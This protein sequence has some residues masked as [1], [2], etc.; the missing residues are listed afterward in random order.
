VGEGQEA[1]L[2]EVFEGRP[3]KVSG[4]SLQD[5]RQTVIR[6]MGQLWI[7]FAKPHRP[8]YR[9]ALPS[10]ERASPEEKSAY[11]TFKYDIS[12]SNYSDVRKRFGMRKSRSLLAQIE[13][14]VRALVR[15]PIDMVMSLGERGMVT[16]IYET[17]RGAAQSVASRISQR[18]G[19]E[20]FKIGKKPVSIAFSYRLSPLSSGFQSPMSDR[21]SGSR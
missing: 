7:D 19:S 2:A 1:L 9:L 21:G 10:S 5:C 20:H 15:Y 3:D 8:L 11:Q 4:V 18:L 6:Q 14:S 16:A 12:I 17:Q 13:H